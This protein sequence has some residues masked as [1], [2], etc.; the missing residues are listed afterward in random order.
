MG[1]SGCGKSTLL[2]LLMRFYDPSEGAIT[3]DGIDIRNFDLEWLR[4]QIAFVGQEPYLLS[5]T[6]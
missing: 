4:S 5:S 6:I 1:E 2:Q 3:I